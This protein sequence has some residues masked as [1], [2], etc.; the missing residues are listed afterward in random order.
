MVQPALFVLSA[1]SGSGKTSL[2]KRA[3]SSLPFLELSISTTTRSPRAN[4]LE[5]VDYHF[6]DA[7]E[8]RRSIDAGEF[9][10]WAEVYGNYYGTSKTRIAQLQSKGKSVILDIDVQGAMQL[11][12]SPEFNGIYLFIRPPSLEELRNRLV[13]RGTETEDSLKKRISNAEHELTF[14]DRYDHVILNDNLD[15]ATHQ[16]LA[17]LIKHSVDPNLFKT[18]SLEALGEAFGLKDEDVVLNQVL[19]DLR[20]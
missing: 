16:F 18:L 20:S 14:Q 17:M 5:G 4:E 7:E 12:D 15:L 13:G 11:Q 2:V 6:T 3:L 10:E 9:V 8:F 19:N 1:P